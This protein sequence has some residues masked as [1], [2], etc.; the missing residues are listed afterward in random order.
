[1]N[2][3]VFERHGRV[4]LLKYA[5]FGIARAVRETWG[6]EWL[7]SYVGTPDFM[8]PEIRKGW[9]HYGWPADI[10]SLGKVRDGVRYV[11]AWTGG[12]GPWS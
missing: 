2:I 10:Y 5:D 4:P 3:L 1:M 12:L 8:A 9:N 6:K 11:G 7:T